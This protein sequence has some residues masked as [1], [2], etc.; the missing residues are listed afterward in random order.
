[1]EDTYQ[2]HRTHKKVLPRLWELLECHVEKI[3]ERIR[4][5]ERL[6]SKILASHERIMAKLHE[7]TQWISN[8]SGGWGSS[9]TGKRDLRGEK[10]LRPCGV[11]ANWSYGVAVGNGKRVEPEGKNVKYQTSNVKGLMSNNK[12]TRARFTD[13]DTKHEL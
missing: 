1:M 12:G 7:R 3:D 8:L 5:I 4:N 10:V 6:R 9:T 11:A 2:I 13:T